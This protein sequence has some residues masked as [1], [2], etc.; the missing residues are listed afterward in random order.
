M[1]HTVILLSFFCALFSVKA[2][3]GVENTNPNPVTPSVNWDKIV[4]SITADH[5]GV[6]DMSAALKSRNEKMAAFFKQLK[7]GIMRLHTASL[8]NRWIDQE[9]KCWDTTRIKEQ[10]DNGMYAY[11]HCERTMLNIDHIPKFIG[12][13]FNLTEQQE[14]EVAAFCGQLP[15]V[16]RSLGYRFDMYEFFNENWHPRYQPTD[17]LPAYWRLLNKVAAAVKKADPAAKV[18]GSAEAWP[19]GATYSGFIDNCGKNMDFISFHEYTGITPDRDDGFWG[20]KSFAEM[21]EPVAVYAR[22]KGMNHLEIIMDEIGLTIPNVQYGLFRDHKGAAWI[23]WWIK[24]L[25]LKGITGTNHWNTEDVNMGLNY[26]TALAN[27]YL[28]SNP[29]LRGSIAESSVTAVKPVRATRLEVLP[30]VIAKGGKSVL[31]INRA[32]E[33]TT[34]LNAGTLL[35]GK[36]SGIKG[37]RLDETTRLE[38]DSPNQIWEDLGKVPV[39]IVLKPYGLV[40]LTD[41]ADE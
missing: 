2:Q 32:D 35:G 18:G 11:R 29:Y 26:T 12:S 5:W 40:L 3:T 34:V 31:L 15:G 21:A 4:G 27:L 39:D 17:V 14:D 33:P 23:A 1:K 20:N 30:V 22:G 19:W 9:N 24:T 8:I 6:N 37:W 36:A 13:Q 41:R 10:L 38:P 7:P 28:M 25:A 16:L